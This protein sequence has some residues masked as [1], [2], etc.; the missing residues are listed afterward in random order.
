MNPWAEYAPTAASPWDRRKAGH[1]LRRAGFG[2]TVGELDR[3]VGFALT[4]TGREQLPGT[5]TTARRGRGSRSA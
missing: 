1:L 2:A 5:F 4:A 3:P